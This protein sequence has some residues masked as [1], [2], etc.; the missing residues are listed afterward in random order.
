M[1]NPYV[2]TDAQEENYGRKKGKFAIE[3]EEELETED[4]EFELPKYNDE[5]DEEEFEPTQR[6]A[7]EGGLEDDTPVPTKKVK[8]QTE[9]VVKSNTKPSAAPTATAA[10]KPRKK[11]SKPADPVFE[12]VEE[13]I[14]YKVNQLE[15]GAWD[16]LTEEE[17]NSRRRAW[18]CA[19]TK[20]K[21]KAAEDGVCVSPSPSPTPPTKQKASTSAAAVAGKTP[22]PPEKKTTA[23]AAAASNDSGFVTQ[24]MLADY[25]DHVYQVVEELSSKC[26][27]NAEDIKQLRDRSIERKCK[28]AMN[29][30]E[31]YSRVLGKR[32]N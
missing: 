17:K 16:A 21:K 31:F 11:K 9:T 2:D 30:I 26:D 5:D 14:S 28:R 27:N 18:K 19:Y 32:K 1:P 6:S 25:I 24:S 4:E 20:S 3:E 15:E 13:C 22:T 29:S 7:T 8:T 12:T 23:A 10:P